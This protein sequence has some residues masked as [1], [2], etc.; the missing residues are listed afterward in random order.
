MWNIRRDGDYDVHNVGISIDEGCIT[1]K[2]ISKISVVAGTVMGGAVLACTMMP[3]PPLIVNVS[4]ADITR[5]TVQGFSNPIRAAA[6][7]NLDS[8]AS[9]VLGA[10]TWHSNN[11]IGPVTYRSPTFLGMTGTTIVT[12]DKPCDSDAIDKEPAPN[13]GGGGGGE[14]VPTSGGYGGGGIDVIGSP[15]NTGTVIVEPIIT[16]EP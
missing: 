11:Y 7:S 6:L 14:G 4:S 5:A 12:E 10:S 16:M 2:K 9:S 1:M 8:L 15:I 3:M 13:G